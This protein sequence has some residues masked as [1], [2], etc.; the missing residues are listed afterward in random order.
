MSEND[1]SEELKKAEAKLAKLKKEQD[2][3]SHL[4]LINF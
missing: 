3:P 4:I 1:L 2:Q